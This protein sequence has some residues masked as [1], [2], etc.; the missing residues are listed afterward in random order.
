MEKRVEPFTLHSLRTHR[1]FLR[2][3]TL[4][5]FA[6]DEEDQNSRLLV[7]GG[8]IV[9]M[10]T[11]CPDR[12]A[13]ESDGS[14]I[15]A[16]SESRQ[17]ERTTSYRS[18]FYRPQTVRILRPR[19]IAV[20]ARIVSRSIDDLF[21]Q[22]RELYWDV[23]NDVDASDSARLRFWIKSLFATLKKIAKLKSSSLKLKHW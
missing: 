2:S 17:M 9:A 23:W 15:T 11:N 22:R 6:R 1:V 7:F 19:K 12:C 4:F 20:D 3:F 18:T 10:N 21:Q 14:L 5:L 8:I 16:A 13:E